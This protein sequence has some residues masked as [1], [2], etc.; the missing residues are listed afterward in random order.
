MHRSLVVLEVVVP[1]EGGGALGV[2]ARVLPC[3]CVLPEHV[4]L[5]LAAVD[6]GVVTPHSICQL[7]L[8]ICIFDHKQDVDSAMTRPCRGSAL[9]AS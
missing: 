6:S 8:R 3:R 9:R 5:Q 7:S 4:L 1:G 2:I